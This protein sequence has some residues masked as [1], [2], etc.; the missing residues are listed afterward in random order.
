MFGLSEVRRTRLVIAFLFT[1][2]FV[3]KYMAKE[4]VRIVLKNKSF[5]RLWSTHCSSKKKKKTN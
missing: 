2:V 1:M 4:R 5:A 3:R